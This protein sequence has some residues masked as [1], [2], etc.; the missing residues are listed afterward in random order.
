MI[1][2]DDAKIRSRLKAMI[3][4]DHLPVEFVCEAADSDTAKDLYLLYR[5][6]IIITDIF[7]PIITG[8]D[9]AEEF[10]KIDPE[11]RLIVITG[12]D[13]FENA[14]KAIKLGA[15]D[16]LSKP[17]F[18]EPVNES[19]KKAVG[20]F[21]KLQNDSSSIAALQELLQDNLH[22]IQDSYVGSLL[23]GEPKDPDRIRKKLRDLRLPINGPR[24]AA[25]LL[26]IDS[27]QESDEFEAISILLKKNVSNILN[28]QGY[29][30]FSYMD[31]RFRVSCVVNLDIDSS[32]N[33]LEAAFN[34][35][36]DEMKLKANCCVIAGIGNIVDR[37]EKLHQSYE[38]ALNALNYLKT[39]GSESVILYSNI[40]S[41]VD[42]LP[43]RSEALDRL[44][45]I[46]HEEDC[47][48]IENIIRG[49]AHSL[50]LGNGNP[51]EA[52]A[53]VKSFFMEIILL[54]SA[55]AYRFGIDPEQ[56][57]TYDGISNRLFMSN[58]QNELIGS[59]TEYL[60]RFLTLKANKTQ[61]N[62]NHLIDLAIEYI[63]SHLGD[64]N[65]GLETVSEHIG[66]SRIYFCKLFHKET[67]INFTNYLKS[68]RIRK[69]KE[70][71]LQTNMKIYEVS[72]AVGFTNPKY[73]GYVFKQEVGLPPGDF[74][75]SRL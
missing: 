13:D 7:I 47:S 63:H 43:T 39:I 66:V 18:P 38:Q 31:S 23:H 72:Y 26:S 70:L 62:T 24:Y 45:E 40:T 1:I 25:A 64:E 14:K 51:E 61:E 35:I 37:P 6:K 33:D 2:D 73:F 58:S 34:L 19:L 57:E 53:Q 65:L 10:L 5:P 69:A 17:L 50:F 22:D 9:L 12:Y 27:G 71:L 42:P 54:V 28:H 3:D 67:G 59:I 21:E 56:I 36:V 20:Y 55:E 74:Q 75:R 4:W 29:E 60:R 41:L 52:M 46:L 11:I 16:L 15:V 49:F 8:L 44:A 32:L 68:E 48:D 30:V